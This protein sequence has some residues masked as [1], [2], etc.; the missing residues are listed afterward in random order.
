MSSEKIRVKSEKYNVVGAS[1]VSMTKNNNAITLISLIVTIII[2]LVL[3]GVTINLT[4]GE[5][6]LFNTAKNA[7][8]N[9]INEEE[10]ELAD[11]ENIYSQ[12]KIATGED[13]KITISMEDLNSLIDKK[14]QEEVAKSNNEILENNLN[15][16]I[17]SGSIKCNSVKP[18]AYWTGKITFD[19]PF[20]TS[21]YA[22]ALSIK[23]SDYWQHFRLCYRDVTENGFSIYLYNGHSTGTGSPEITWIAIPYNE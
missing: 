5:N 19:E 4:I 23:V 1:I 10:K 9:Y 7:G 17:K 20:E 21:N 14:V 2:L 16:K 22:I 12:I 18:G 15:K 13:S 8:K 3:A 6:G 11:L